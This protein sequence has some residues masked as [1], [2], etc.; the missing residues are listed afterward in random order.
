[1]ARGKEKKIKDVSELSEA[2]G[3]NKKEQ[4]RIKEFIANHSFSRL[5]TVLR[6]KEG[7]TE[8]KLASL[9]GLPL[10]TI[11]EIEN[12]PNN[13]IKFHQAAK[14]LKALGYKLKED[15]IKDLIKKD[16]TEENVLK[17]D[18]IDTTRIPLAN[19]I[20]DIEKSSFIGDKGQ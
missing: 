18:L 11:T 20:R 7:I 16:I 17:L 2:L 4:K 8:N 12:S 5:L 1:M 13:L 15:H 3:F 6:V 14:Y 19:L 9:S 10:R